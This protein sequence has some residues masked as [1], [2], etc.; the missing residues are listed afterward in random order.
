MLTTVSPLVYV[1]VLN[2]NG[3]RWLEACFEALLATEY[4]N[5]RPV[6]VDNASCDGSVELVR[7][8]F[9]QVEVIINHANCGFAEGNNTGISAALEAGAD[10]VVL[11]NPDTKVE[12]RWLAELVR[13]GEDESG[14]GILGSVQ[15]CYD[16]DDFNSWTTTAAREYLG[17]LGRLESARL[18]IPV[19]WVEG[20][21]FAI[22]RK[23]LAEVGLL[24]PLYSSFYEEIDFCRRAAAHGYK[25]AL[26]PRSRIRHFRGGSWEAN[27]R[28]KRERDYRCNRSQLIYSLSDPRRPMSDNIYRYLITVLTMGKNMLRHFDLAHSLDFIRLQLHMPLEFGRIFQKWRAERSLAGKGVRVKA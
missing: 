11:L 28:L 10:Y 14:V 24:D 13:I 16:G 23:V 1:I 20:S 22:K 2:Y 9:P 8:R 27:P 4:P 19:D 18:W 17:E 5:F 21:C 25:V 3:R 7:E 12:P 26:I 6:L 15:L